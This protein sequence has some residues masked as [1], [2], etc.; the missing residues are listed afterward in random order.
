M[1]PIEFGS[2]ANG[3]EGQ[4]LDLTRSLGS[5]FFCVLVGV[6]ALVALAGCGKEKAGELQLESK[7]APVPLKPIE[8]ESLRLIGDAKSLDA[9]GRFNAAVRLLDL[10]EN[11]LGDL[12]EADPWTKRDSWQREAYALLD[13]LAK[14]GNSE[15]K[16]LIANR[17]YYGHAGVKND[18]EQA[19]ALNEQALAAGSVRALANKA[20]WLVRDK[21][22]DAGCPLAAEA[23]DR[24]GRSGLLL[25]GL[26]HGF[27]WAGKQDIAKATDLLIKAQSMGDPVA[28]AALGSIYSEARKD[29]PNGTTVMGLF[30]TA[31]E[32]GAIR[33]MVELGKAYW[34]G[35]Y[36][37]QDY[38]LARKWL[39]RAARTGD[40]EAMRWL[41]LMHEQG[42]AGPVNLTEA[43]FW[44]NLAVAEASG[45]QEKDE[46]TKDRTRVAKLLTSEQTLAAQELARNWT[47]QTSV[48][49]LAKHAASKETAPTAAQTQVRGTAFW[50]GRD[51]TA[52]TNA[53]VVPSCK[54][55][56]VGGVPA[57]VVA[58]DK[59]NDLAILKRGGEGAVET[60]PV[61]ST[62]PVLGEEVSVFGFALSEVLAPSGNFTKGTVTATSGL[63][64]NAAHF[65]H[66][67]AVQPGMSGGPMLDE[68]G[69]VIGVVVGK[70]NAVK[71][72]QVTGDLSQNVNFGIKASTVL[73]FLRANGVEP[74]APSRFSLLPVSSS[75]L[76]ARAKQASVHVECSP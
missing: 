47:P 25:S 60:L 27:G 61:R 69:R 35:A 63:Q 12:D 5:F 65:Q 62:D 23:A 57:K 38:V 48:G 10:G 52:I 71:V 24:S 59:T 54:A 19:R 17:L 7:S 73:A 72:A 37:K 74:E 70:L 9:A 29:P 53:H 43:Y 14:E 64:N 26:C 3:G 28:P 49:P 42:L 31:A 15:A 67:A 33:G 18:R 11:A 75:D 16:A 41:G 36:G 58:A 51:G 30:E 44:L 66:S 56:T 55:L 50:I 20:W 8:Q 13:A 32:L 22:A 6:S 21:K 46:I 40:D 34:N 39:E 1:D 2:R 4:R 76:A 45:T 68:K